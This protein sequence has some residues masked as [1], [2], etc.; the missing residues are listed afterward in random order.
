MTLR[1]GKELQGTSKATEVL[2]K[3]N[4]GES[5]VEEEVDRQSPTSMQTPS[6]YNLP[7]PFP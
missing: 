7:F 4:E 6:P 2:E 3:D 1:S 5:Q